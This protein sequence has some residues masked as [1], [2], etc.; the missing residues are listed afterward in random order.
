MRYRIAVLTLG[1]AALTAACTTTSGTPATAPPV[2]ETL[3]TT[4]T[5]LATTTTTAAGAEA[6]TTTT[7]D[8][9]SEIQAIYEDLEHR[10]L[11]AIYDQDEAAFRGVYANEEYLLESLPLLEAIAFLTSPGL[12]PVQ[13][14]E[15]LTDDGGCISAI[16]RTDLTAITE[17]GRLAEKQQ[18]IQWQKNAWG[19]SY[20]GED[21]SCVGPHPL[22]G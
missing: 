4:T 9:L 16:V 13:V 7:I 21:W 14:I 5:Q 12:Y 8:R 3:A 2:P 10:R 19:I 17:G 11:Q 22:S 20:T 6:I 15:I 1:F 18:T